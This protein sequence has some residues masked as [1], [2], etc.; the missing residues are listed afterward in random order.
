MSDEF[1]GGC[2][3]ATNVLTPTCA[4]LRRGKPADIVVA[5]W[6]SPGRKGGCEFG[7]TREMLSGAAKG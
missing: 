6:Q 4:A 1:V 5:A 7:N 2:A 3:G